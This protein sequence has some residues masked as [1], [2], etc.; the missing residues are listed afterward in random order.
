MGDEKCIHILE[1][2]FDKLSSISNAPGNINICRL[3]PKENALS[4]ISAFLQ[5]H[6]D[7]KKD[8]KLRN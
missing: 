1:I 4:I 5:W 3:L 8:F 7:V 6:T 2:S